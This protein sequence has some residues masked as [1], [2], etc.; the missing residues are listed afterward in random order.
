MKAEGSIKVSV[1]TFHA[2]S[3]M[4]KFSVSDP[5]HVTEKKRF[6]LS[7]Q[8]L[9][10]HCLSRGTLPLQIATKKRVIFS[11]SL[12]YSGEETGFTSSKSVWN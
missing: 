7:Y 11:I 9:L 8:K 3:V 5:Q 6:F 1:L 4:S 12:M 10:P 2:L